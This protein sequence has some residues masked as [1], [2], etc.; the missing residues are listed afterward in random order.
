MIAIAD[1]RTFRL[2]QTAP[3]GWLPCRNPHGYVGAGALN[4]RVHA[5]RG[6]GP[7]Q[8]DEVGDHALEVASEPDL[9]DVG[10]RWDGRKVAWSR[11]PASLVVGSGAPEHHL[12]ERLAAHGHG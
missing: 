6:C 7:T 5:W 9:D 8:S 2:V 4:R 12:D 1:T 11:R 3:G 10:G